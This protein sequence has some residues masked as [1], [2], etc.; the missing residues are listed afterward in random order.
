M[1]GVHLRSCEALAPRDCVEKAT[2]KSFSASNYKLVGWIMGKVS[3]PP[4]CTSVLSGWTS[5]MR[6]SNCESPSNSEKFASPDFAMGA[7]S[8]KLIDHLAV[9]TFVLD[10]DGRVRLWNKACERLTGI[11]AADVIG[12]RDHWRALYAEQRPCLADLLLQSCHPEARRLYDVWSDPMVNP[13]GL[14]A[15]ILGGHAAPRQAHVSRLRRQS[16]LRRSG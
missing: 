8:L 2:K 12:S 15:E 5:I 4:K 10:V 7:F 11:A 16:G 14:S 6:N 9:A 1:F 13:R 3:R